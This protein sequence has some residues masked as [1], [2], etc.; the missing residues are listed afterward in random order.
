MVLNSHALPC[1]LKTFSGMTASCNLSLC[2]VERSYYL[3]DFNSSLFR[4][5]W[6]VLSIF[7]T[8]KCV[9]YEEDSGVNATAQVENGLIFR[10]RDK[11]LLNG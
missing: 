6:G 7:N 11:A 9:T 2:Y 10:I 5:T 3:H 8:L 4:K 1:T